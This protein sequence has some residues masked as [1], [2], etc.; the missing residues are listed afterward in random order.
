M[1]Q[2]HTLLVEQAAD[3]CQDLYNFLPTHLAVLSWA[4]SMAKKTFQNDV[5]ELT[6]K[7][8]GLQFN[9]KHAI[10][11]FVEGSFMQEAA[12]KMEKYAPNLW[13]LVY[14]LLD[15]HQS[16]RQAMPESDV[17]VEEVNK[18]QLE[19]EMDLSKFGGD[20][21]NVH[22][23]RNEFDDG[24]SMESDKKARKC[25]HHAA[26]WNA[27]L[28]TIISKCAMNGTSSII[29]CIQKYIIFISIIL[30]S[31]NE[32]CNYLQSILGIFCHST[33]VPEKVIRT[34]AHAGLS[35]SL[36]PIHN[37][38]SS[39]SKNA[40]IKIKKT[41]RT[42][43]TAFAYDNFRISFIITEPTVEHQTKFVSVT[44][45]TVISLF[46]VDDPTVL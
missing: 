27:T 39:L 29:C 2:V 9:T 4:I 42:L 13:D 23:G 30:Q 31:A 26:A 15:S 44:S 10:L 25:Q 33:S 32:W 12:A 21:M 35:I 17:E 46:G 8:H 16:R 18:V 43:T 36:T 37:A 3:I 5:F 1:D 19:R 7:Q 6:Q 34:L 22:N 24:N 11:A 14:L 28:L 41:V 38:I 20:N 45:A 40:A